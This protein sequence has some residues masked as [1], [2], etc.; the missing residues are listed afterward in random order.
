MK[1]LA[2]ALSESKINQIVQRIIICDMKKIDP[3]YSMHQILDRILN[4]QNVLEDDDVNQR[5]FRRS[6]ERLK[7]K[8]EKIR[9]MQEDSSPA[10]KDGRIKLIRPV[11]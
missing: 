10:K 7:E 4:E 1:L 9:Q 2:G 6:L 3:K 8:H 5:E 11:E